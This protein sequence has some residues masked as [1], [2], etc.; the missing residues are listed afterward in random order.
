V[1]EGEI[2]LVKGKVV[3]PGTVLSSVGKLIKKNGNYVGQGTDYTT[4]VGYD[5]V[6][7][8]S[9]FL[10]RSLKNSLEEDINTAI[11]LGIVSKFTNAATGRVRLENNLIGDIE[12]ANFQRRLSTTNESVVTRSILA[13][14]MI[15][16]MF[17]TIETDKLIF[18]DPAAFKSE[19]DK[20]KRV[21]LYSSTGDNLRNEFPENYI[22][23]YE[24]VNSKTYNTTVF[25]DVEFKSPHLEALVEKHAE[26]YLAKKLAGSLE[27]AKELARIKLS[28]YEKSNQ[29]D[30]QTLITPEMW[31]ALS[32]KLGLFN[33]K[34]KEAFDLLMLDR[35]LTEEEKIKAASVVLQPLKML[36]LKTVVKGG[37]SYTIIDKMSM[38]VLFP[39]LVKG[40]QL[41]DL[42]ERMYSRGK[43]KNKPRIDQVKFKSVEKTGN[44]ET[45]ELFK[46]GGREETNDYSDIPVFTQDFEYLRFQLDTTPHGTDRYQVGVQFK[47]VG[48]ANVDM[49]A[50]YGKSK[51]TGRKIVQEI[52]KILN[53]LSDSGIEDLK[54]DMGLSED[55]RV[56]DKAAFMTTLRKEAR[57]AQLP[58]YIVESFRVD[59]NNKFYLELNAFPGIQLWSQSRVL[60]LIKKAAVDLE[61]PGTVLIQ[62]SE[63]GLRSPIKDDSLQFFNK[64]GYFEI[65]VSVS[66]FK[67]LIPEYEDKSDDERIAFLEGDERLEGMTYR[68]PTQGPNSTYAVKVRKFLP[69]ALGDVIHVPAEGPTVG[70]FDFDID[71]LFLIRHNYTSRGKVVEFMGEDTDAMDRYIKYISS[72]SDRVS[73]KRIQ[74]LY[75]E[76]IKEIRSRYSDEIGKG[77]D[78]LYTE[79]EE[80]NAE[81]FAKFKGMLENIPAGYEDTPAGR[82]LARNLAEGR[83]VFRSLPENILD[84]FLNLHRELLKGEVTG[85]KR[86]QA[87]LDLATGILEVGQLRNASTISTLKTMSA[88]YKEQLE[89]FGKKSTYIE[90]RTEAI[91]KSFA[92]RK[93]NMNASIDQIIQEAID[94]NFDNSNE[95]IKELLKQEALKIGEEEEGVPTFKEFEASDILKQ[96]TKKAVENKLLDDYLDIYTSGEHLV[97]RTQP[98]SYGVSQLSSLAD[99]VEKKKGIVKVNKVAL[100]NTT[101]AHQNRVKSMYGQAE[102]LGKYAL[103]NQHFTLGQI[104][105]LSFFINLGIGNTT[106][107]EAGNTVTDLSNIYSLPEKSTKG[108]D[109]TM[110]VSEWYSALMDGN[111]DFA[112]DPFL[113]KLN[114]AT[115]NANMVSLLVR[116]GMGMD[117]FRFTV[118]PVLEELSKL[119][120]ASGNRI[121]IEKGEPIKDLIGKYSLL[122]KT[123]VDNVAGKEV[124]TLILEAELS[125]KKVFN[126]DTLMEDVGVP[127][128]GKNMAY[129]ERQLQVLLAYKKLDPYAESLK[130][131]VLSSR[132]DAKKIGNTISEVITYE[133]RLARVVQIEE[134]S[135]NPESETGRTGIRNFSKLFTDTYLGTLSKNS[136]GTAKRVMGNISLEGTPAFQAAVRRMLDMTGLRYKA[137]KSTVSTLVK[138]LGTQIASEHMID[139]IGFGDPVAAAKMAKNYFYGENS[140]SSKVYRIKQGSYLPEIQDNE[141]IQA[142]LSE[143]SPNSKTPNFVSFLKPDSKTSKEDL[144]DAW[145]DMLASD[146]PKVRDFAED[147]FYYSYLSTGFQN[148]IFSFF[149]LVP[150]FLLKDI[151]YSAFIERK[152]RDYQHANALNDVID[153]IILNNWRDSN[154]VPL[155]FRN[156]EVGQG[157]DYTTPD[158]LFLITSDPKYNVGLNGKGDSIFKR[159][160][161]TN[162]KTEDRTLERVYKYAGYIDGKG[163]VYYQVDRKGFKRKGHQLKENSFP[164]S[165]IPFNKVLATDNVRSW[166]TDEN[167]QSLFNYW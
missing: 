150:S 165:I 81:E 158:G 114:V 162:L 135:S 84:R 100:Q 109:I 20:L 1:Q 127:E 22:Y 160:I 14:N 27:K 123:A 38:A 35:E 62:M 23:N 13:E 113:A 57:K 64:D 37:Q 55:F 30:G 15:N 78:V 126:S 36:Y 9:V 152:L 76:D 144:H 29:T 95:E 134:E 41:E 118:Q 18:G 120:E 8:P 133:D 60:S 2:V 63:V 115:S 67:Q 4:F 65:D 112:S 52:H 31:R 140:I 40:T 39:A 93:D 164:K 70:G 32:I 163:A 3:E 12:V 107:D 166:L 117:T 141:L 137:N 16:T 155:I 88:L 156:K 99:I 148:T 61:M 89:I 92:E 101:P 28:L 73:R 146:N 44:T 69:A 159:F 48:T 87:F 24:L 33:D 19:E 42:S 72:H 102:N 85:A 86:S 43:Y 132:V 124:S 77:L 121:G 98:L 47:K 46:D 154:I 83:S 90:D 11:K 50:E 143:P 106:K 111:M 91:K 130:N 167:V 6:E 96:N 45:A 94:D 5:G 108:R 103:A 49:N 149:D 25:E 74:A 79:K 122:Y 131:A 138:E 97:Y 34:K 58:D 71:K 116:M 68:I 129:Y 161:K 75:E 82:A 151:G 17:S 21:L 10:Q 7:T 66:A 26:Y 59:E 147:L 145:E 119:E 54:S 153:D 80:K 139:I 125:L 51:R 110:P 142:L 128:S 104:V 157:I 136:I 56:A 105:G 53:I